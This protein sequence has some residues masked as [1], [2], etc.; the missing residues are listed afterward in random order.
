MRYIGKPSGPSRARAGAA[1][2]VLVVVR[3]LIRCLAMSP[4]P[5]GGNKCLRGG[6]I[7]HKGARRPASA[8]GG[9]QSLNRPSPPAAARPRA[10]SI[11]PRR[12]VTARLGAAPAF[13]PDMPHGGPEASCPWSAARTRLRFAR[14][15]LS[16]SSSSSSSSLLL[17]RPRTRPAIGHTS[18]MGSLKLTCCVFWWA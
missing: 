7:T 18:A 4:P 8:F 10:V 17:N 5:R 2:T 16:S 3:R 15:I 11:R 14:G 12:G 1:G 13:F 6:P 9:S